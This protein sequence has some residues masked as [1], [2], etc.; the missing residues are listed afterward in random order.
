MT[1]IA[2]LSEGRT[3]QEVIEQ[4]LRGF[5]ERAEEPE[6]HKVF[7]PEVPPLGEPHE[8]GWTVLKQRLESGYHRQALQFNDYV[9][10]H[11]DTDVC[12][13]PGFDVPRREPGGGP[14]HEPDAL[15]E[16]TIERLVDW[17][18]RDFYGKYGSRV[19][20]A[21]AVDSIE[22][23]LLPLLEDKPAKQRK[24][25]GCRAAAD[26]ALARAGK[27]S[28]GAY[29]RLRYYAEAARPYR[30]RKTLMSKGPRNPSLAAFLRELAERG[31]EGQ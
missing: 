24:T 13:E 27:P 31:I 2:I 18:G 1:T 8:G 28:L 17:L 7:P 29:E 22:C 26:A 14:E 19:L 9:V 20:F 16:A 23:W 6:I 15:R 5:F 21:I 3:D 10:I 11:I 4:V 12:E 25:T 30:K